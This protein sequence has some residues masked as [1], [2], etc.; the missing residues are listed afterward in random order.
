MLRISQVV[1]LEAARSN[2]LTAEGLSARLGISPRS[3][4]G[5]LDRLAA[6]R[7]VEY[8]HTAYWLT[9]IGERALARAQAELK[10]ER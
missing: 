5:R 10:E 9:D 8:E 3:A 7:C 1:V 4:Q 6:L 2:G